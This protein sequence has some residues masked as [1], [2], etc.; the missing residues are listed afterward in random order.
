M[1]NAYYRFGLSLLTS[2]MALPTFAG[3]TFGDA[4]D[5]LGH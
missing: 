4:Q 1:K 2:S 3:V 5:D